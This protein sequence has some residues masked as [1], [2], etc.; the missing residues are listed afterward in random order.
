MRLALCSLCL[1]LCVC[2]V[3]AQ[4][5]RGTITGTVADPAGAVIRGAGIEA[6]NIET[7]ALYQVASTETGNYTLPQLPVGTYQL[8]V[9]VSG[10]KQFVRTGI[11]V[12]VAQTL[13]IDVRLE[14]GNISETVTVN[15]DAPLLRTESGDL[16]HNVTSQ[17]MNELPIMSIGGGMRS[18]YAVADLLPGVSSGGSATS[19]NIRMQ[20][21]PAGTQT[22]RIEGQDANLGI[23]SGFQYVSQPSVDAID[24]FAIQTSNFAAE[25]GQAGG[26]VMNA[27][28]KS[29]TNTLH[30]SAYEYFANEALNAKNAYINQ[31]PRNRKNDYG[32]TLGGPVYIPHVYDGHDRTFFFFNFEQ[33]RTTVT[34][35]GAT[36][37]PTLAMRNGDFSEIL[38]RRNLCPAATPNCALNTQGNAV[39]LMENA[40]YDPATERVV[41]GQVIR[42][43]FPNNQIPADRFDSVAAKIQALVPNPTNNSLVNNFR[44]NQLIPNAKTIPAVKIDH[45]ISPKIKLSG[46]WSLST[47]IS[48]KQ[49]NDGLDWPGSTAYDNPGKAHTFRLNYDQTLTPTMLLHIGAG[50]MHT[51]W[52]QSQPSF[53]TA[54]Q[55]GLKGTYVKYFPT[56][57]G[58]YNS[59]G[60]HLGVANSSSMGANQLYDMYDEKPTGNASLTWVKKNHTYKFG[61]ELRLQGN[62][63]YLNWPSNGYFSFSAIETGLP[64]TQGWNLQGGTV[65]YPYASFLLG[66]A[67]NGAIGPPTATRMGKNAWALFAQDTWK[68]RRNLTL[69]YGLRWDYQGYLREQY[70]RVPSI[71]A[72]VPNPAAGNLPGGVIFEATSGAF[73]KIYP[74]AFGPRLGVAYQIT[75]KTVFRGGWGISYGQTAPNN[76]WSMRFGSNVPY[77]AS[78]YGSPAMLLEDGV[79]LHPA[80]PNFDSG[81]FP[82]LPSSPASFLTMVDPGAG[83]P[84]RLMMWSIGLQRQITANLAVEATYVGNRGVWWQASAINDPNRLTP[85]I[86]AANH[87]DISRAEDRNLLN[88]ALNSPLAISRGFA[89]PPYAS[90]S[91]NLTVGQAL[92]PLPQ[93][94]GINVLWSP[95]GN[96]WYDSLQVK[97]T[98]RYSQG[99]DLT[100]AYTWQKELTLGTGETDNAAWFAIN[101]SVNNT[102]DRAVNKYISGYSRPHRLVVAVNYK[103]P[104]LK[105]NKVL[106]WA[107]RDWTYGAV[108][109]YASALPIRVPYANNQI[110]TLL[111]LSTPMNFS[112][113]ATLVGTGTFA[114]RVPGQPLFTK[115]INCTS[116]FDPNKNFVLNPNAWADPADGQFGTSAAYYNDYRNRRAPAENM[117]LGRTFQIAEKASLN[118]RIELNNAFNRIRVP[119]IAA[120]NAGAT[121]KVDATGKPITGFGYINTGSGSAERTGQI[122]ARIQF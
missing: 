17:R 9:S 69:D 13:R 39:P 47:T 14:V 44:S 35:V 41:N 55:L 93:F 10:F 101:A 83:R 1:F 60:G 45:F 51:L 23:D 24:E 32:F 112:F 94:T 5:D 110:G 105:T 53:D 109:T 3:F 28:V 106:S 4:S 33:Y 108:L 8:T 42:D 18:P 99:L 98:K 122:V 73:A 59:F 63:M 61:A 114:N 91:R 80:W 96:T 88:S 84:P 6:K 77:A 49:M 68:V 87:L 54:G 81:Q 79:P 85:E 21:T 103:L 50:F 66:A 78:S 116:C 26:G 67:N 97:V 30:G 2:V 82:A 34:N 57:V 37:V 56:I 40:I 118:I 102:L 65:G 89:N 62:P 115:D 117:S 27:T 75:P 71:S 25:F 121:Q 74:F 120:T 107:I 111:K 76:F 36:T 104:S 95:Q 7:G 86:L 12:L 19:T 15:A 70:G 48:R 16:S 113:G 100:A 11:T 46:Y 58:L 72:S 43:P 119:S 29:G 90:F 20:G 22:L 38:T 31:R 64:S 52:G 92:R